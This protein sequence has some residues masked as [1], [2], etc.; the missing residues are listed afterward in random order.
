MADTVG[1]DGFEP[2][3]SEEGRFTVCCRWPLGYLPS[4]KNSQNPNCKNENS[5]T[6]EIGSEIFPSH[7]SES[8]QRPTDY[9]SVALPAELKW[10]SNITC[11]APLA[12]VP[13]TLPTTSRDALPA[14]LKWQSNITC[15]A[16]LAV[17]PTTFPTTSRD[18]L[19]AE[20]KWH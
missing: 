9:K 15:P 16:R 14:E 13:P 20:L 7:L 10:Q 8:N 19:P 1:K 5:L 12:V 3:N 17:V 2:P 4:I 6:L 11:P 18:A